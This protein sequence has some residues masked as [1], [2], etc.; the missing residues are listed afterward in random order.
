[1][2]RR[3]PGSDRPEAAGEEGERVERGIGQLAGHPG[4]LVDEEPGQVWVELPAGRRAELVERLLDRSRGAVGPVVG[5]RVEGVDEPDDPG[6]DRDALAAQPVRVAGPV[7]ALVVVAD[8]R[9]EG[10]ERPSGA[11]MR[12]P[13][14]GW[15]RTSCPLVVVERAP[16]WSGSNP[17][18]R[19][20]RRR[21]GGRR[22]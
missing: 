13:I 15:R 12:S 20:C 7:P 16:P 21:G 1:M 14:S 18:P 11:Q 2:G 10:A 19:S 6:P 17:G 3:Q 5:D 8:D 4:D 22:R 9:P